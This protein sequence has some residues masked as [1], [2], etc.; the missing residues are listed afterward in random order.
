MLLEGSP[1]V[2]RNVEEGHLGVERGRLLVHQL[3]DL[4]V[5][6]VEVGVIRVLDE[7]L[8]ARDEL[9]EELSVLQDLSE[10]RAVVLTDVPLEVSL[11]VGRG[12]A[13]GRDHDALV[14]HPVAGPATLVL[15]RLQ[16][17][18]VGEGR[19][20]RGPPEQIGLF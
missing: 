12:Q 10:V 18:A 8:P 11:Q 2:G 9:L 14:L 4:E 6:E 15:P 17:A 3:D 5:V 7:L 19:V 13:E 16:P 20:P 1:Q